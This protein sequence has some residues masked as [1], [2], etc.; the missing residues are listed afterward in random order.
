[1]TVEELIAK[2]RLC[3][4]EDEVLVRDTSVSDEAMEAG[5]KG[6]VPLEEVLIVEGE[7]YLLIGGE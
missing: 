7:P 6:Y 2:L 4:P 1:M 5:S 3:S